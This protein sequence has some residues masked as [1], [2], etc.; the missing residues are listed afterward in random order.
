MNIDKEAFEFLDTLFKSHGFEIRLCGG[1]VR[2]MMLG[3]VPHDLDFCTNAT[4][5]DML[6]MECDNISIIRTGMAHGTL[7]F[8]NLLG[9]FE[10]T[11]LR[12]DVE[13]DGRHAKVVFTDSWEEDAARRDFTINAMSMNLQGR[14]FDYFTGAEDLENGVVKFVGNADDRIKEDALRM[15]RWM[16]FE[17][18]FGKSTKDRE[19]EHAIIRNADLI[20]KVSPER[21]W[22]EIKSASKGN[23]FHSFMMDMVAHFG[24]FHRFG[25]RANLCG[26]AKFENINEFMIKFPTFGM[27]AF[28][29]VEEAQ[30]FAETFK[31]SS[32]EKDELVFFA[33]MKNFHFYKEFIE[34]SIEEDCNREWIMAA[35]KFQ[36]LDLGAV[37]A[38]TFIKPIFPIKGGDLIVPGLFAAGPRVGTALNNLK[39]EWVK[40]RFT[41]TKEQLLNIHYSNL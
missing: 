9:S 15:I 23:N 13:T 18:R 8:M 33:E 19:A 20:R 41:L 29:N 11:T 30:T 3:Q 35:C 14:V 16:R 24:I 32:K 12:N 34:N 38:E 25:I 31:L 36:G 17:A 5:V 7:T 10:V 21:I 39:E 27:A 2:D 1:A 40:S 22:Q 28:L 26:K 4:P 6:H 37:H